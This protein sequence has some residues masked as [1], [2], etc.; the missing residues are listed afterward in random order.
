MAPSKDQ[1]ALSSS[2][3]PKEE[4]ETWGVMQL[5]PIAPGVTFSIKTVFNCTDNMT[6][7]REGRQ[8]GDLTIRTREDLGV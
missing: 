6:I 4:T 3:F 1:T 7:Q 2:P 5:Y 8:N